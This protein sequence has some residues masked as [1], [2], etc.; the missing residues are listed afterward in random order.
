M[1]ICCIIQ[2]RTTSSRLPNKVL[3]NLP[4][5]SE[6]TVLEQVI[7][8]VRKSKMI[9]DIIVATTVNE[10]DD[11]IEKLCNR[12][13]VH[14]YRGSEE[15]VLSRYYEA[16][17]K[18]GADYILRITS[19]CPCIDYEVIDNLIKLHLDEKNDFTSNNQKHTFPH[20]LDCE[21][22]TYGVLKDAFDNATEKYET[23]H[24]MP[25]VY[26]SNP[27]KYKIGL[28]EDE[29][30]NYNI[31]ITL[32]TEEDYTVLCLIYDFLYEENKVFYKSD[33]INLFKRKKYLYKINENI[34]QKKVCKNLDE[35]IEEAKKL[36]DKQ[37]LKRAYNFLEE[38]WEKR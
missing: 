27:D 2:V 14:C 3:L 28:L 38:N 7:S 11:G 34:E 20:G 24:V 36:L 18:Y 1:R 6:K 13:E 29:E 4:Y 8:R 37:D 31:R 5:N 33:I 25:Y 32:D 19:D 30:D 21:M 16:A 17:T 22:I 9:D 35:E 10:T 15:N 12:L 26:K 23:E